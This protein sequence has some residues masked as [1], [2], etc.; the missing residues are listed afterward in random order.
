MTNELEIDE[1]DVRAEHLQAVNQAAHWAY[2]SGVLGLGLLAMIVL[3][4]LLDAT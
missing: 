1:D 3:I 4:A 2:L